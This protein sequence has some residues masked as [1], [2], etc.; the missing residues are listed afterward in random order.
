MRIFRFVLTAIACMYFT[1]PAPAQQGSGTPSAPIDRHALVTRHNIEVHA[2]DPNGAMAVG[3]GDFAFNFDVTGLQSFPDY[4]AK[5][6]PIGTLSDW[7]WHSFPNPNGY[8][9]DRFQMKSIPKNGRQFVFPD[10]STSHPAP[11]A[12]YLRANPQRFGLGRI[13][14]EM[15][16][17][18]GS[19]VAITDLANIDERLD[20]WGGILTSSFTVDG[21]P[22]HV[23]T[24][25]H[26]DRDEIAIRVDSPL[27]ASGRIKVRIAFPYALDSFGP[28][29]QDW[30]H[31]EAHTTV[32]ARRGPNAADFARTLDASHYS[33]RARW[34]PGATLGE[35]APHQYLLSS[36]GN[37]IEL[38]TWF[39]PRA[40]TRPADSVATVEAA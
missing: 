28:D 1:S 21:S 10:A 35:T 32:V 13:G 20:L 18:D 9:L 11:D 26:P 15:T 34:S 14:L 16:H 6:M 2:I 37:S 8:S 19:K 27:I 3:N 4:Y 22:V 30:D 12:A 25:A 23:E 36:H 7:G 24:I 29:Y 33:V 31:P 5:T 38:T 40:V 39:S 17:A